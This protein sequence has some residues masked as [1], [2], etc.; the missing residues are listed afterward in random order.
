M[1]LENPH[2]MVWPKSREGTSVTY[3]QRA[4]TYRERLIAGDEH[5]RREGLRLALQPEPARRGW[6]TFEGWTSVDCWLETEHLVLFIE[7]KRTEPISAATSWFPARN[8]IVR[9]LEVAADYARARHKEFAVMLCA[10]SDVALADDAFD[11]S[12]PHLA[13]AERNSLRSRYLGCVTWKRICD[14]LCPGL[15]LPTA[16]TDAVATC[17]GF[18]ITSHR[19]HGP[20]MPLGAA[21]SA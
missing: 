19:N 13:Q 8:Q 5:V 3:G 18:A 16:V 12:L 14:A 15:Q 11:V 4:Q 1:T 20:R 7:G 2:V 6:W 17:L 9:N 10:E 21:D